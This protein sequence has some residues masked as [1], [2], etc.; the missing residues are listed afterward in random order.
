MRGK[1]HE[2]GKRAQWV[3]RLY[4]FPSP[5]KAYHMSEVAPALLPT[6]KACL[7][8]NPKERP[9]S[10][11]LL[12]HPWLTDLIPRS[13]ATPLANISV[14]GPIMLKVQS[15]ALAQMLTRLS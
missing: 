6:I 13:M 4:H 15:R 3:L 12:K 8:R 10:A 1:L 14:D 11:D 7:S 2:M 9:T 5:G